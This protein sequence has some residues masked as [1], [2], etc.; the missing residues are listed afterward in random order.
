[1]QGPGGSC[2]RRLDLEEA[3]HSELLTQAAKVGLDLTERAAE[4]LREAP[5]GDIDRG[6]LLEDLEHPPG[7]VVQA[8]VGPGLEIQDHGLLRETPVHHVL[9]H[10]DRCATENFLAWGLL[11]DTQ[12]SAP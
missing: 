11:D 7:R 12:E 1:M 5:S 4:L 8:V 3:A 10:A 9:G 6:L 2:G